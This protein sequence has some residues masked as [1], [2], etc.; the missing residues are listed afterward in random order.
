MKI[1]LS[2][3]PTATL[4]PKTL[5]LSVVQVCCTACNDVHTTITSQYLGGKLAFDD[6]RPLPHVSTR[7]TDNLCV[8]GARQ[9]AAEFA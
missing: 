2:K 7:L 8:S 9:E 6:G 5:I 4:N 3:P 1:V